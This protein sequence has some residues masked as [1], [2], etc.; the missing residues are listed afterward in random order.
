MAIKDSTGGFP[1]RSA[2]KDDG[3][4]G[5]RQVDLTAADPS[6]LRRKLTCCASWR[7]TTSAK[8]FSGALPA[9]TSLATACL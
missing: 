3:P 6:A 1:L 4:E 8:S 5:A 7:A 2:A 9:A